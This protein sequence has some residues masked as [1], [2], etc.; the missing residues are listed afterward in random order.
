MGPV[1]AANGGGYPTEGYFK[2]YFVRHTVAELTGIR[3]V[4]QE[5]VS[6]GSGQ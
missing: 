3:K 4:W 1:V 5:V 2:I 6:A